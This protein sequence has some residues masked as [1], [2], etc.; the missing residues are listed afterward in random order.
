[1]NLEKSEPFIVA[2][3]PFTAL[4]REERAPRLDAY[5]A[6]LRERDGEPNLERRTL[7]ER[8]RFGI[9]AGGKD[10]FLDRVAAFDLAS[11][12]RLWELGAV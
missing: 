10:R 1:M 11:T 12:P 9:L 4:P 5:P 7:A 8:E 6:F 3:D 2:L